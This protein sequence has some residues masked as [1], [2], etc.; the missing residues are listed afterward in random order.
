MITSFSE[1]I[2]YLI[3]ARFGFAYLWELLVNLYE[4]VTTD[5]NVLSIW[6]WLKNLASGIL[7]AVP[8]ILMALGVVVLLF[9]KKMGGL[10][11]FVGFFILGFFLGVYF[12]EP[13]IPLEVPISPWVIGIIIAIIAAVLSKFLFVTSYSIVVVYSVYRLCYHGFFFDTQH[14]FSAGKAITAFVVAA[15]I[16]TLTLIFFRFVEMILF[17]AL[18]AWMI[19]SGF[20]IGII[21]LGAIPKLGDKSWI[22]EISIIGIIAVLGFIFQL[23]T[24][25]RY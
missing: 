16:L 11:K 24:R 18:G 23:K 15:I 9:G 6:D 10:V 2:E 3:G 5:V 22:L 8:Y 13:V 25:K 7:G 17:S 20:G 4:S 14:T 1:F 12:L 19:T 21:D